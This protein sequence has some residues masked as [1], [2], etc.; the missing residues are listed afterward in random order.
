M[1]SAASHSL[2]NLLSGGQARSISTY[3]QIT[4]M[5]QTHWEAPRI[6]VAIGESNG[7]YETVSDEGLK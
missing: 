2:R 4:S 6:V 1:M 3:V 7:V 5:K